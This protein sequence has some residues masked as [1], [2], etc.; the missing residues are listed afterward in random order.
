MKACKKPVVVNAWRVYQLI[1]LHG[2]MWGELP[3]PINLALAKGDIEFLDSTIYVNT[4]EGRMLAGY[5][6][7]II[8][9]VKGE[10]YP[11]KED[12]FEETYD[13]VLE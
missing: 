12:V 5:Q 6:D 3:E 11:C 2:S 8:E 10:L 9:G 4:L 13:L 7:I 1:R